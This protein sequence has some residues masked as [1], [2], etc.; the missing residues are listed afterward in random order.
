MDELNLHEEQT[1]DTEGEQ[2][3]DSQSDDAETSSTEGKKPKKTADH[4]KEEQ[5]TAW[6]NN[7]RS[8]KK[9]LDD[10]PPNLNW[11]KSEVES[12]LM[13][14]KKSETPKAQDPVDL[15]IKIKEELKKQRE[16]EEKEI[17][18]SYLKDGSVSDDKLTE[19]EN[20]YREF[21]QDG[22]SEFNALKAA[23][24]V[25][26]VK[27]VNTIISDKKREAMLFPSYGNQERRVLD[28][29]DGLSE[30]ERK[31]NKDLPPGFKI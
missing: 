3:F 12:E 18:V 31:F 23:M 7:I 22:L 25:A 15:S 16:A 11:L 27:D 20:S 8:G 4:V 2:G 29:G 19:V 24:K 10:M 14:P 1:P 17:L 26:G 9:T 30:M 21:K 5:K 13:P 28:K 6:L